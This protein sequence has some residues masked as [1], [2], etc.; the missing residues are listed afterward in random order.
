MC[1]STAPQSVL[2]VI[3]VTVLAGSLSAQTVL[4][5]EN[6]EGM[7]TSSAPTGW[8]DTGQ[9]SSNAVVSANSNT[10]GINTSSN[11][12]AFSASGFSSDIATPI[13]DITSYD[14]S[15][16]TFTLSFD[17]WTSSSTN[18]HGGITGIT[19]YVADPSNPGVAWLTGSS[20]TTNH[21]HVTDLTATDT[22]QSFSFDIT[23]QVSEYLNG[24]NVN[25]LTPQNANE[26]ALVFQ[27]WG[28]GVGRVE[29]DNIQLTVVPEP[30]AFAAALGGLILM[31]AMFG[32]RRRSYG[33]TS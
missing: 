27:Q 29:F 24:T 16:Y 5:S 14:P 18:D 4:Y 33:T 1:A 8:L 28:E 15:T 10:T 19:A 23:T 26:F 21:P 30:S 32:R 2:T 12:L 25:I 11:V 3:L 20:V 31:R 6:F 7:S 22:W 9:N 13:I 17:L